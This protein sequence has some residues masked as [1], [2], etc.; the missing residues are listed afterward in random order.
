MGHTRHVAVAV[1]TLALSA[2]AAHAQPAITEDDARKIGSVVVEELKKDDVVPYKSPLF[3]LI[4]G[5]HGDVAG[6]GELRVGYGK[7]R[8][9]RKMITPAVTLKRIELAVRGAYGRTDSVAGSLIAGWSK[10]SVLGI[11][12]GAGV[13]VVVAGGGAVVGPIATLGFR[14]GPFGLHT[15]VWSH[16]GDYGGVGYTV[17]I[18]YTKNDFKSPADVAKE[19]TK[20]R[21]KLELEQRGIPM[22]SAP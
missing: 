20:E 15:S 22:P 9:R 6:F 14:V 1:A 8:F 7:G 21:I 11:Q 13:D 4:A 3:T 2:A 19:R 16:F 10:V 5:Y 12:L 17:G 18:G